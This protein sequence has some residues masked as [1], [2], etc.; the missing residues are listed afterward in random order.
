MLRYGSILIGRF[1][2]LENIIDKCIEICK[3]KIG[4]K[5]IE[6][7]GMNVKIENMVGFKGVWGL[8]DIIKLDVEG[9]KDLF[10]N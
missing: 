3:C 7:Y 5:W 6:F 8:S 2:G 1:L 9:F 10:G 4:L